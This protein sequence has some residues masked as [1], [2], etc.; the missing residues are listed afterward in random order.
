MEKDSALGDRHTMQGANDVLLLYTWHLWTNIMDNH[1]Q[2]NSII[3]LKKKKD[4]NKE[5]TASKRK[6]KLE[7][8]VKPNSVWP[9]SQSTISHCTGNSRTAVADGSRLSLKQSSYLCQRKHSGETGY[10]GSVCKMWKTAI[11]S[12]LPLR[13][14][15]NPCQ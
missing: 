10:K 8:Q 2:Y 7:K 13:K 6:N 15:Q 3:N 9:L 5:A 14:A 12:N 11:L 1:H 4:N